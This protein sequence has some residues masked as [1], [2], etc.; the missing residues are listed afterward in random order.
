MA[1]R[2][3]AGSTSPA[4]VG[5]VARAAGVSAQTVSNVMNGRGRF[6]EET[7]QRVLAAAERLDYVPNRSARNLRLQR[8]KQLGIHMS[9]Q[10]L[11]VRNPFT[12]NFLRALIQAGE[13]LDHQIVVFTHHRDTPPVPRDFTGRGVDGFVLCNCG[14]DD[15][16]PAILSELGIP[17]AL[18]GRTASHLPQT[19]VDID[20]VAAMGQ[21]VDY[22]V[23]KGHRTFGYVGYSDDSYW[24]IDRLAG[25]RKR[26]AHHGLALRESD[27]VLTG[28]LDRVAP[29]VRRMLARKRRPSAV[30][31]GSDSLAVQTYEAAEQLG[32]VVGRDIALA[33]FDA[34]D[35][36]APLD[37]LLT[38]VR[39]PVH[40]G[41]E[42]VVAR[43]VEEI[44]NGPTGKPGAL[45]ETG[46]S[47]GHSA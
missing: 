39:L 29:G 31:H 26:L 23:D 28:S 7:R 8:S 30:I 38:S 18:M 33:G 10:D 2:S 32:L 13:A 35:Q 9:G 6:T 21:L 20:N 47:V 11:D 5:D 36:P 17:F 1:A 40:E 37:P 27:I 22:L 45:M 44:E 12:I 16:R 14:P 25:V 3:P 43:V 42:R 15:P 46:I 34:V 19:W 41:A 4:R 24:T